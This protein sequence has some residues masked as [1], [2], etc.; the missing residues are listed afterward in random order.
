MRGQVVIPV[1][2]MLAAGVLLVTTMYA[3]P[4]HG[5]P[6]L[7]LVISTGVTLTAG[8]VTTLLWISTVT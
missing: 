4:I 7:W 1:G 8:C 3:T 6:P 2:L 5:R